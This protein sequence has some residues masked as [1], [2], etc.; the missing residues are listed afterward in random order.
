MKS[1]DEGG[2]E[3][4]ILLFGVCCCVWICWY[5]V[6]GLLML[7]V[8][9]EELVFSVVESVGFLFSC[10]CVLDGVKFIF[11]FV[12]WFWVIWISCKFFM[13]LGNCFVFECLFIW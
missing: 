12:F 11:L 3:F 6:G 1:G 5:V 13:V 8:I 4:G 2:E 7:I 10:W 9:C